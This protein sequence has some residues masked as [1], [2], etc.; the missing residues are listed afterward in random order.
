LFNGADGYPEN[1]LKAFRTGTI[2]IINNSSQI[3]FSNLPKG[4]YAFSWFHDENGNKELD[5]NFVGYPVESFGAS[6]NAKGTFGP[7]SFADAK[8]SVTKNTS[9][10]VTVN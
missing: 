5:K 10:T 1:H 4:D 2:K 8:V 3:T 9:I 7:P 6:N